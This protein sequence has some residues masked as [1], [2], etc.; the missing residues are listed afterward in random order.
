M[1]LRGFEGM[2]PFRACG[3]V[4]NRGIAEHCPPR[5]LRGSRGFP[6][7]KPLLGTSSVLETTTT[8]APDLC[9]QYP[10]YCQ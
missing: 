5:V 8:S 2:S 1:G 4:D 7:R 3:I 10:Y 6:V 9:R